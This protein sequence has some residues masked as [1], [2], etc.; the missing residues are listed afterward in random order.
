M[1]IDY[2]FISFLDTLAI[3]QGLFFGIIL[4]YLS[5]KTNI[6][7]LYLGIFVILFSLEPIPNILE[8]LE[9]LKNYPFLELL[10][11]HFHFLAYPLFF[12]YI[13]KITIPKIKKIK[14]WILIPGGIELLMGLII[15]FLPLEIK[16]KIKG[17][18]FANLYFVLGMFYSIFI[19]IVVIRKVLRHQKEINKQFSQ[20]HY[21]NLDWAKTFIYVSIFFQ[22]LLLLNFFI[23]SQPINYFLSILNVLLIYGVSYKGIIQEK[24]VSIFEGLDFKPEE[25]IHNNSPDIVNNTQKNE[26][27]NSTEMIKTFTLLDQYINNS[28]CYKLENITIV[29]IANSIQIHPKRISHTLNNLKKT[30][31]NSYI[32]KYRIE[33]AKELLTNRKSASLSIEGIGINAGFHS[34]ATFYN[35]FKKFELCT[36]NQYKKVTQ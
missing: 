36:P 9:I 23:G 29:D 10:P 24:T 34:K 6:S 4:T 7:R 2:N 28:K 25:L 31:F 3:I 26:F 20:T 27:M 32:N 18:F 17:S 35:A 5:F 1:N 21:K 19:G 14:Y 30:N 16:L 11:T 22:I 8:E 13:Q 12:I 15:F 33:Y